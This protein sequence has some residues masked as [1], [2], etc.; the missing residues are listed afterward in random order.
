[1]SDDKKRNDNMNYE[2]IVDSFM[3]HKERIIV[4]HPFHPEQCL[5]KQELKEKYK[6]IYEENI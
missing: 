6:N 5:E 1:M 4:D 3:P 2:T